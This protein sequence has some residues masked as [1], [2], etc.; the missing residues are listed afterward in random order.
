MCK[1]KLYPVWF[2]CRCKSYLVQCERIIRMKGGLNCKLYLLTI[3]AAMSLANFILCNQD[4]SLPCTKN[5]T[6]IKLDYE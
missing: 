6:K 3:P 2:S 1:Q 4:N 5:T